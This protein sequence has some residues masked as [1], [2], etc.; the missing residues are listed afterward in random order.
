[1][2]QSGGLRLAPD[3]QAKQEGG[4][5]YRKDGTTTAKEDS[6]YKHTHRKKTWPAQE[7]KGHN[8]RSF[9]AA[10]LKEGKTMKAAAA[11]WREQK[12]G[13]NVKKDG[14]VSAVEAAKYKHTHAGENPATDSAKAPVSATAKAG[15]KDEAKKARAERAAAAV[16]ATAAPKAPA[17]SPRKPAAKRPAKKAAPRKRA[18]ADQSIFDGPAAAPKPKPKSPNQRNHSH[19]RP[20]GNGPKGNGPTEH[21]P[22]F[23]FFATVKGLNQCR[24]SD[25]R[26]QCRESR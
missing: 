17:P 19:S 11:E 23:R 25:L 5:S 12:G 1:M 18:A 8:Y 6:K 14:T 13:H 7:G 26:S 22:G 4:H 10:K 3:P 15:S 2:R 9:V 21:A 24:E 20:S 16:K